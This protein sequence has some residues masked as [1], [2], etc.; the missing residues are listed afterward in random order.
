MPT[1]AENRTKGTEGPAPGTPTGLSGEG[2]DGIRVLRDVL[3]TFTIGYATHETHIGIKSNWYK[4]PIL[5]GFERGSRLH[6]ANM[7]FFNGNTTNRYGSK[8]SLL[9]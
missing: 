3:P 6:G 8:P 2:P 5:D 7:V 4:G 9:P 1:Q